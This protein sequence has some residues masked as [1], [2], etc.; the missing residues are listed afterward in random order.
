MR[1]PLGTTMLT[2]DE[3]LLKLQVLY[4]YMYY[5][6]KPETFNPKLNPKPSPKLNPGEE[7]SIETSRIIN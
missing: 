5:A 7:Q 2:S 4:I 6:F 1:S 3:A